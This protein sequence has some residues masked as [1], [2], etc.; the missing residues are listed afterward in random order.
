MAKTGWTNEKDC[1][2]F[3]IEKGA[4]VFQRSGKNCFLY[5]ANKTQ[6][7]LKEDDVNSTGVSTSNRKS[8]LVCSNKSGSCAA[9]SWNCPAETERC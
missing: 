9:E 2:D 1:Y 4:E 5:K 6:V 8:Y 7:E 3:A